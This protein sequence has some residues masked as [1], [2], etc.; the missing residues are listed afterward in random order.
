MLVLLVYVRSIH[1]LIYNQLA[2]HLYPS[3]Y[4]LIQPPVLYLSVSVC[5]QLILTCEC[6]LADLA[7]IVKTTNP[8][9]VIIA[10]TLLLQVGSD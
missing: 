9:P 6:T 2:I 10:L 5:L 3:I 7:L 8:L 1:P 4:Q